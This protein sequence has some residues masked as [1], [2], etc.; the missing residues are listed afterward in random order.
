MNFN[1]SNILHIFLKLV[2]RRGWNKNYD[3][4]INC[5]WKNK[6]FNLLQA[7]C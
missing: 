7:L 3:Y 2:N 6:E 5:T 4:V 1:R